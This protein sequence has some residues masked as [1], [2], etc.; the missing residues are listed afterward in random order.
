MRSLDRLLRRLTT[1]STT[2]FVC[3]VCTAEYERRRPNCPA[4]GS[5]DIRE[6]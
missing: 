3:G 4:C 1:D 2:T 5:T 6:I